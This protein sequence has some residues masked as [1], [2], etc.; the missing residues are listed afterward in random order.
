[1][2][3]IKKM[4]NLSGGRVVIFFNPIIPTQLYMK[5]YKR[6]LNPRIIKHHMMLMVF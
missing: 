3:V 4:S 2:F 6:I 5:C 1:M